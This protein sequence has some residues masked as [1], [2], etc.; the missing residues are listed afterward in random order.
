MIQVSK[1]FPEDK[2]DLI[3]KWLNVYDVQTLDDYSPQSLEQL[4]EKYAGAVSYAVYNGRPEPLGAIWFDHLGDGMYSGHLV[5]ERRAL[6]RTDIRKS[7]EDSMADLFKDGRKV[8][9]QF[10]A[11]N[12]VFRIFLQRIGAKREG[13][14]AQATRRKGELVDL[15]I[16]ASFPK[17]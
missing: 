8:Y 14:L 7:V 4:R 17:G 10:L 6:D 5:F 12:R 2:L 15:E 11:D 1:P 16:M 9:W 3:W 13:L